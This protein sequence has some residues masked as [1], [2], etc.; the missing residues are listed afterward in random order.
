PAAIAFAFLLS[1]MLAIPSPSRADD[2]DDFAIKA[3]SQTRLAYFVTGHAAV[4]SIVKAGMAGLTLVL[5]QRTALEA[6][7]PVGIDPARDE[8]AF[9]PLIYWPIVPGA[10]KP[11]QDAINRIDAYMKQGGTVLFDTRDAIEAPPGEGGASQ[12]PGMQALRNI[13]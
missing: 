3:V 5:A 10:S 7:D 2:K 11:P 8:L 9:F 13:L 1:A 12:T 4:D 6:G